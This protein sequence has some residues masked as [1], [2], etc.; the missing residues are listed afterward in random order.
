MI[1]VRM[2]FP[3]GLGACGLALLV[4]L[5]FWQLQRLAWK[6]AL[7]ATI[8][9]AVVAEPVTLPAIPDPALHAYLA[10][11]VEG[12]LT[13]EGLR[14]LT[15]RQ[16]PGYRQIAVMETDGRRILV[17]LGF[18]PSRAGVARLTM[19]A[20]RIEGNLHWPDDHDRWFTPAPEGDVWFARDVPA[21]AAALVTEPI[22]VVQRS[23]T[24]TVAGVNAWPLAGS[25]F[26]NT[27][28]AYAV[29]WFGLALAW[30]FMTGLW[31]QRIRRDGAV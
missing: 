6:E 8:D 31:V 28:F 1:W 21:M 14:V 12:I 20:H 13:G 19:A 7:I 16:E 4:G 22:L 11:T 26:R 15:S 2:V 24:P 3:L 27:H 29:T 5:G 17:D 23:S 30:A 9:A 18:R 10:V 25:D